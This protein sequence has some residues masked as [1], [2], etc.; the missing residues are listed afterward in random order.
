V[1]WRT[2]AA[3]HPLVRWALG[4]HQAGDGRS[5]YLSPERS[6]GFPVRIFFDP[7]VAIPNGSIAA[8]LPE[9]VK[10]LG[11]GG[12]DL[13]TPLQLTSTKDAYTSADFRNLAA[14]ASRMDS[15]QTPLDIFVLTQDATSTTQLGSTVR[16][17]GIVV[18]MASITAL[19]SEPNAQAALVTSTILHEFGHQVGLD[20]LDDPTCI[21]TAVVEQPTSTVWAPQT[22]PTHYCAA[23][24]AMVAAGGA[25]R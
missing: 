9:M 19:T 18:F 22:V 4:L 7:E 24:L 25:A 13:G 23:E 2:R 15:L 14:Q 17:H 16:E 8:A 20:H 11:R 12:F 6:E 10:L 21:M 5:D 1:H 3:E